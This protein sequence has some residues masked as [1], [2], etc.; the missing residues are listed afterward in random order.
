MNNNV[1]LK[2][3]AA[4]IFQSIYTFMTRT[5]RLNTTKSFPPTSE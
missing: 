1:K 2:L 4:Q 5:N 3:V